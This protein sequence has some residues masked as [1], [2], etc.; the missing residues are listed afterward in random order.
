[1]LHIV[2]GFVL[3]LGVIA[4]VYYFINRETT[5][6]KKNFSS[7][8][9]KPGPLAED[10]V[11]VELFDS[12][13]SGVTNNGYAIMWNSKNTSDDYTIKN[14]DDGVMV[15]SSTSTSNTGLHKVKNIPLTKGKT[16]IVTINSTT[17]KILFYPI[18]IIESKIEDNIIDITTE[19]I[20]TDVEVII[21][22]VVLSPADTS[23]KVEP[24][25]IICNISIAGDRKVV[26]IYNGKNTGSVIVHNLGQSLD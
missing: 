16:Y 21:G 1:M 13:P 7:V 2:I 25:G 11:L 15:V 14:A 17:V 9:T 19:S 26:M 23:I 4:I 24:P 3:L 8:S 22:S 20:P 18:D 6:E 12:N 5:L 10:I